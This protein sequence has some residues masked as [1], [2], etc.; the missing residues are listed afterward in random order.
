MT[1]AS[2]GWGG[3]AGADWQ[4]TRRSAAPALRRS[5]DGDEEEALRLLRRGDVDEALQLLMRRYSTVVYRFCRNALADPVLAEDVHQQVFLQAYRDL[6]WFEPRATM[7]S[8]IFAIARHR[9]LD[10]VKA[11]RRAQRR[12]GELHAGLEPM[13]EQSV[14][15][16]LDT[17]RLQRALEDCVAVL[18]ENVRVTLLLR[19][20]RGLNYEEIAGVMHE[21]SGALQQRVARALVVLR[22]ALLRAGFAPE[23]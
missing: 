6:P 23:R 9:V 19:Y 16:I 4:G 14:D 3:S 17:A 12:E 1:E 10:A 5:A 8:W 11:R 20:Q 15:A 21:R 13:T 22:E 7:R 18:P 2:P